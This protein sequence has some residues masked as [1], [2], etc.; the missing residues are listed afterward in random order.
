MSSSRSC[1]GQVEVALDVGG[2][3]DV[4]DGVRAAPSSRNVPRHDL[5]A[6][7]G[8]Q[9]VDAGQV[10]DR[11]LGVA[12]HRAVLAVDGDAGEV[13][14]VLVGAG[15]LVEQRRL[16]AVLVAGEA[17]E[18]RLALG[19][20]GPVGPAPPAC[21]LAAAG[22]GGRAAVPRRPLGPGGGGV[23]VDGR[24]ADA[25]GLR[26]AQGELIAAQAQ[27]ERVAHGGL[28]DHRDDG[29]GREAHVE[30]V[31]A[32]LGV[33]GVDGRD[34]RAGA[35]G[36][37]VE[38]LGG[39]RFGCWCCCH[40]MGPSPVKCVRCGRRMPRPAVPGPASGRARPSGTVPA[41]PAAPRRSAAGRPSSRTASRRGRRRRARRG[42]RSPGTGRSRTLARRRPRPGRFRP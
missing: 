31:L 22:V 15:E 18:Q 40:R 30:D 42:G 16:A 21:L 41:G 32:Q 17:E 23:P 35:D 7:V 9:G 10:G 12:A 29:P 3:D 25:G 19:N 8:R 37:P 39:R 13:A 1:G 26:L 14:D 24:D 11:G 4:D 27:L 20:R 36:E 34:P 5:L 28:L 38:R 6:G 33:V 2:V